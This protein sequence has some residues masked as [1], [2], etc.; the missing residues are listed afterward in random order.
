MTD[1]WTPVC[2][3]RVSRCVGAPRVT[4]RC[5]VSLCRCAVSCVSPCGRVM[6][7]RAPGFRD[8]LHSFK[9]L[10]VICP[11]S[12]VLDVNVSLSMMFLEYWL[13]VPRL[14]SMPTSGMFNVHEP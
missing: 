2:A 8:A 9:V 6:S 11:D 1:L 3:G 10:V 12:D 13:L 7:S 4:P 5:S 14:P